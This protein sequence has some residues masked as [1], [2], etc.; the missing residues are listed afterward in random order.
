MSRSL[1]L[2]L[3]SLALAACYEPP[4]TGTMSAAM[5]ADYYGGDPCASYDC[6]PPDAGTYV[7]E[8]P[9]VPDPPD[10]GEYEPEECPEVE[11]DRPDIHGCWEPINLA[12]DGDGNRL[13]PDL[14]GDGEFCTGEADALADA[15]EELSACVKEANLCNKGTCC[16]CTERAVNACCAER[17]RVMMAACNLNKCTTHNCYFP[18]TDDPSCGQGQTESTCLSTPARPSDCFGE[19]DCTTPDDNCSPEQIAESLNDNPY[20]FMCGRPG[21]P[22]CDELDEMVPEAGGYYDYEC[23]GTINSSCI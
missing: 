16:G 14:N 19:I 1:T 17:D 23:F 5:S 18:P 6:D 20:C 2:S 3:V 13:C 11:G 9:P 15:M 12:T 8:D 7:G 10:A 22:T 4:D 21:Q